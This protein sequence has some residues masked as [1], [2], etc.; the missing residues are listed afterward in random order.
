MSND[1][2]ITKAVL[3]TAVQSQS[4][5]SVAHPADAEQAREAAEASAN[6]IG[7]AARTRTDGQDP[8]EK[9]VDELNNL[10]RDL[11]REL[12]FSVDDKSGDTVIKVVDSETDEVVRQ[13]PSEEVVRLRQRLQE[14]AGVIFQDSA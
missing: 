4:P 9:V 8:L 7:L 3:P 14:V 1:F 5:A 11:H 2:G 12:Q 10:V 13:I 6:V